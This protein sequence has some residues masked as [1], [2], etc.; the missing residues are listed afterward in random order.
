MEYTEQLTALNQV[1]REFGKSGFTDNHPHYRLV[2]FVRGK[3]IIAAIGET[4]AQAMDALRE[5]VGK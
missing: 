3:N 4:W 2:G 1:Q 5:K